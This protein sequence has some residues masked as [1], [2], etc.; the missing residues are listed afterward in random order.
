MH[1]NTELLSSVCSNEGLCECHTWGG[2]L[3][4]SL[5]RSTRSSELGTEA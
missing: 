3:G 4:I 1:L 5:E 2:A